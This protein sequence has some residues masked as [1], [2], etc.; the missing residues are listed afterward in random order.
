MV[1][2]LIITGFGGINLGSSGFVKHN[3][4]GGF[5]HKKQS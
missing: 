5:G 3:G 4:A 1:S 2:M